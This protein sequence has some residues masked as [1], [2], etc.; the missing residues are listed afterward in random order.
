MRIKIKFYFP[1]I[2]LGML[3]AV[4]IFAIGMAFSSQHP[5]NKNAVNNGQKAAAAS[6]ED[7]VFGY[8]ALD[9][10]T[11]VLAFATIGLGIISIWGLET[12]CVIL[13]LSNAPTSAPTHLE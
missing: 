13:E 12:N 5:P 3:L 1:E 2:F 6:T 4:A 11:C 10:F 8:P 9:V 7:F